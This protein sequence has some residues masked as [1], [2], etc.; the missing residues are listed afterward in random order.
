VS[1]STG[2]LP[3]DVTVRLSHAQPMDLEATLAFLG[4]RVIPGVESYK[5]GCYRRTLRAPGGPARITLSPAGGALACRLELAHGGDLDVVLADARRLLDLDADST[6]IDRRLGADPALAALVAAR[7]GL[8]SPGTV[9]GFELA[10]RA[11]VGQQ[12]S[13]AGAHTLLGRIAAEHGSPAF[14]G[15]PA[16]LFPVP[17]QLASADPASLPMP[18]SRARTIS[19]LATACADGVLTLAPD[20]DP[21]RERAVL[22]ALPGIGPWT[23]DYIRMRAF[24]DRDVLL[25]SDLGVRRSAQ[26]LGIELTDGRPD[27]AP[28]RSYA[29]HHLWAAGH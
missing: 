9:D 19:A 10:I 6:A 27:W 28:W 16:Q 4:R 1:A 18:R 29:T 22:L 3:T 24:G 5:A 20:G 8:R 2:E 23:T 15:P 11:V 21:E 14:D 13:V 25:S 17:E 12:I 26:R 7:P